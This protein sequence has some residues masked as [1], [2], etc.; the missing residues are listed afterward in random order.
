MTTPNQLSGLIAWYRATDLA[1]ADGAAVATWVDQSSAGN[2]A[3]QATP[4]NQPIFHTTTGPNSGPA[5]FFTAAGHA[6]RTSTL[7]ATQPNT[8]FIVASAT[9]NPTCYLDGTNGGFYTQ[10]VSATSLLINAGVSITATG[11]PAL[12]GFNIICGVFNGVSSLLSV[13]GT[14]TSGNAGTTAGAELTIGNFRTGTVPQAGGTAEVIVYN[15]ALTTTE[16][17][18]IETYLSDRHV[19]ALS[20]YARSR[21]VTTDAAL[22]LPV[23]LDVTT[24]AATTVPVSRD[25]TTDAS[26]LA[27][28]TSPPYSGKAGLRALW[29]GKA[30]LR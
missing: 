28:V 25:V 14:V 11:T 12:S 19:I 9:Q 3:T 30:G 7:A 29:S 10:T 21:D 24:T 13:D 6:L 17:R 8:I 27:F 16:R 2:N 1:L 18:Q 5:V 15:R 20:V 22:S 23:S 26:I 4:A